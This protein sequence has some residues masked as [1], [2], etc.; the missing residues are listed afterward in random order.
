MESPEQSEKF[1]GGFHL[2]HG[3]RAERNRENESF[4]LQSKLNKSRINENR[5]KCRSLGTKAAFPP[6]LAKIE[7]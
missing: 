6:K 5:N 1:K 4:S 2:C 3:S 7:K